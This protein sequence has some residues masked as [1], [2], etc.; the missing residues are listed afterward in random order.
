MA[1]NISLMTRDDLDFAKALTD[2]E[3]WG[4]LRSDFERLIDLAPDGCFVARGL[5]RRVGIIATTRHG[6]Y[7]FPGTLIVMK[8]HRHSGIGEALFARA[9]AY[10]K[11]RGT[12]TIELNGVFP[13]VSLYRRFGFQDKYLSLR[14]ARPSSPYDG[15]SGELLAATTEEIVRFDREH[16]Q[17]DRSAVL[18]RFCDDFRES[19]IAVGD[20]QLSAYAFVKS[21]ANG[22]V[23]VGPLVAKSPDVAIALLKT[24]LSRFHDKPILIGV[25]EMKVSFVQAL[26]AE[27]FLYKSP[28]LRMYSGVRLDLDDHT[29][30]IIS[31]DKG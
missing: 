26:L 13:A 18:T 8:N 4:Y 11:D 17:I 21:R 7:G 1:V 15:K 30:V 29:Y 28:F 3:N 31:P 20:G 16:L 24:I 19:L 5:L 6:D 2:A 9:M 22:S 10:L 23:D 27:G 12:K 25:P 14:F